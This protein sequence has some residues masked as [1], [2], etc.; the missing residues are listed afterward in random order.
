MSTISQRLEAVIRTQSDWYNDPE[1]VA[2]Y[3]KLF[4]AGSGAELDS[5]IDETWEVI[6]WFAHALA[7][8]EVLLT[9]VT[10]GFNDDDRAGKFA[11]SSPRAVDTV[12]VHHTATY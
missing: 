1:F 5:L 3:E 2:M 4:S 10:P 8:N 9:Q 7:N 11:G 6:R 12:I